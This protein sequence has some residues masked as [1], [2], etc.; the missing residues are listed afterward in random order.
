MS[1]EE[2][3]VALDISSGTVK[4]R[5]GR[6]REMLR[7]QLG[8]GKKTHGELVQKLMVEPLS[9]FGNLPRGQTDSVDEEFPPKSRS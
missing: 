3:A 4:S 9:N 2:I 7:V 5:L 1:I 8:D 6:G